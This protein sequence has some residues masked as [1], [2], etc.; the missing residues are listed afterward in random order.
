MQRRLS[1]LP[2][3]FVRCRQKRTG[4]SSIAH[5]SLPPVLA[6]MLG[7]VASPSDC[8]WRISFFFFC[9]ICMLRRY[10]LP[11][12]HAKFLRSARYSVV[13]SLDSGTGTTSVPLGV[14]TLW[15]RAAKWHKENWA[16]AS[17]LVVAGMA[18]S[19]GIASC[20]K[21]GLQVSIALL[22]FSQIATEWVLSCT[23]SLV[24]GWSLQRQ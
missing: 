17:A 15:K 8:V 4:I 5:T 14:N 3:S 11:A 21:I 9:Y 20:G 7:G 6:S 22:I 12:V 10:V 24:P 23:R 16:L 19:T 2:G 1:K 18:M 13:P